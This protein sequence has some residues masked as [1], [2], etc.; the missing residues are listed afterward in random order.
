MVKALTTTLFAIIGLGIS[1]LPAF[2]QS[3]R[4]DRVPGHRAAQ[5][6]A[7][8]VTPSVETS[9]SKRDD[10]V[11]TYDDCVK[12]WDRGLHMTKKEWRVV[13]RRTHPKG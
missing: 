8:P 7:M 2:A 12:N 9:A 1:G 6:D 5:K 13:C 10:S 11:G 3:A 4:V